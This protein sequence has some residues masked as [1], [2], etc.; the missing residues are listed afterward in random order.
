MCSDGPRI[1]LQRILKS[2]KSTSIIV[3]LAIDDTQEIEAIRARMLSQSV[4]RVM[5]RAS[6]R[7]PW[8]SRI[9]ACCNEAVDC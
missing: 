1:Q 6:W 2:N 9:S 7:R 5:T 8:P 4:E 3:L